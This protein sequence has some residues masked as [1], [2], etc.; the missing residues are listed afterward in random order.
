[1]DGYKELSRRSE[2]IVITTV[3]FTFEIDGKQYEKTIDV[4]H[5]CPKNEEAIT[6]GINNRLISERK[7]LEDDI[8]I[9][10]NVESQIKKP[11]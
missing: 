11:V 5:F 3:L 8:K 7:E 1:M 9:K 2:T 6:L 4:S 10:D